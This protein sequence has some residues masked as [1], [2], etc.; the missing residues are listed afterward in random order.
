MNLSLWARRW[1]VS[2]EAINDLHNILGLNHTGV[3]SDGLSEAAIQNIIRL[4]ASKKGCR[5]WRNNVGATYTPDGAFIRYGLANE[6]SGVNKQI[7]SADLIGIRPIK[8]TQNMVG[9]TLGQFLS[10]EVKAANWRYANTEREQAQLRWAEL[11]LSF[12][13]DACFVNGEGTI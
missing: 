5:L 12:G 3:V 8:I 11:I 9:A 4:E 13:G 1:N 2:E 10:R 6:S 7:K